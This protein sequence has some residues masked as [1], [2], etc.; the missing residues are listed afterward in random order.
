MATAEAQELEIPGEDEP[1]ENQYVCFTLA[2]ENFAFP[3]DLV[4][5]IVRPPDIVTVP[6]APPSFLGL[7]NL[8][9]NVLPVLD[10]RHLLG[11]TATEPNAATRVV[12]I[13]IG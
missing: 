1:H 5:E 2:G 12:V 3:M 9:G 11:L 8:R 4:R 13:D 10:L 6:L 7:A